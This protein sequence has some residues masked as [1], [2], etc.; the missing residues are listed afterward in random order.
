[1]IGH[2]DNSSAVAAWVAR[3]PILSRLDLS[4]GGP[5]VAL[6]GGAVRDALLGV[7]HGP[8]VDLVVEGDAIALAREVGR[9]LGGRVVVHE[10]FRTARVDFAHGRHLDLVTARRE[11]Y[12][13]PGALPDVE[14]GSLEDDLA[15]RDFTVNAIAFVLRGDAKG[16]LVDPHDGRADLACE[17]IRLIRPGAFPEDPSR[18]VR[19][20]RYA[21]RLGFRMDDVTEAEARLVAPG[22]T[23]GHSRIADEASR[24]LGES[25]ASR[26]LAMAEAI[27][28]PW[29]EGDPRRDD[30]LAALEGALAR[31]G[32]P[33]PSTWALRMGLGVSPEAVSTAALP[34]W[35]RAIAA[36]VRDGLALAP[37]LAGADAPSRV[38]GAL[39]DVPPAA[40]VGALVGGAEAVARWWADWRDLAP[41]V[42]GADLVAAGVAPGPEIGRALRA[43]RAAVLDGEVSGRGEQMALALAETGRFR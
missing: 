11:T 28:V 36:E 38:D 25:S 39:R 15:R 10:R 18:V 34:Q 22:V 31:P 13:A 30:R 33:A 9:A 14:P 42:T 3:D 26:A 6:V 40:Q 29:P 24:L 16:F 23:L 19:A 32:A 7:P 4:G 27:G 41:E 12:P 17:R 37:R 8:D 20:L 5:R 35:S 21:A 1:M 2:G 43:V